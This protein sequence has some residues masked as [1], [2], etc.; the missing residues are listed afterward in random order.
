MTNKLFRRDEIWFITKENEFK[1]ELF[2]LTDIVNYK[3]EKVRKDAV[4]SKQGLEGRYGADPF[5]T[6][7]K[8]FYDEKYQNKNRASRKPRHKLW[9]FTFY[10]EGKK[11]EPNYRKT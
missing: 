2:A 4:Y 10:S 1:S 11:T 6:Q 7:G 3:G 5:I 9:F 8:K